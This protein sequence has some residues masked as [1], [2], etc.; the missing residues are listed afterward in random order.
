MEQNVM[1]INTQ[2]GQIRRKEVKPWFNE[3]NVYITQG[4]PLSHLLSY[5]KY[6]TN[7]GKQ[8]TNKLCI[9]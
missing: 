9:I 6:Q 8:W 7:I 2:N 3:Q 1:I 5:N 4:L